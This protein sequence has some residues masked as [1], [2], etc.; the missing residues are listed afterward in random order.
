MKTL[1]FL[2]ITLLVA[3]GISFLTSL[4]SMAMSIWTPVYLEYG[5]LN[6]MHGFWS[7]MVITAFIAMAGF[8]IPGF[9]IMGATN[10]YEQ[11]DDR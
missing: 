4:V 6:P 11:G 5:A 8:G 3:T 10:G 2:G 9:G 7:N 1:R